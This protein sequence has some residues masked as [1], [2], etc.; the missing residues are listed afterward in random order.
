MPEGELEA[1]HMRFRVKESLHIHMDGLGARLGFSIVDGEEKPPRVK[2]AQV[3][4]TKEETIAALQRLSPLLKGLGIIPEPQQVSPPMPD[5]IPRWRRWI[6]V[7][8]RQVKT[9]R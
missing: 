1:T 3:W 7:L 8:T 5:F 9:V 4:L 2:S 6:N